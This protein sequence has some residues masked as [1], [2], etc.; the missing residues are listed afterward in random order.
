MNN[1][2]SSGTQWPAW[3]IEQTELFVFA[4]NAQCLDLWGR[5]ANPTE[6]QELLRLAIE[7]SKNRLTD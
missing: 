6:L 7:E 2:R 3:L 4:I 5:K 1:T